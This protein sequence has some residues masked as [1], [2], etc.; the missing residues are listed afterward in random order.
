MEG[1]KNLEIE[2]LR[3][4]AILFVLYAHLGYL[5]SFSFDPTF[6]P[7]IRNYVQPGTGV[8]L[9]FC[10]SGFVITRS[11]VRQGLADSFAGFALP[12]WIRRFWR[13][14]PTI[15]LWSP[16]GAVALS[17]YAV[18]DIVWATMRDIAATAIYLQNLNAYYCMNYFVPTNCGGLILY[19][20]LSLEEQF[21]VLF[22]IALWFVPRRIILPLVL[23]ALILVQISIPRAFAMMSWLVRTDAICFGVLLGMLYGTVAHAIVQPR[24]LARSLLSWAVLIALAVI[25]ATVDAPNL[26]F[27]NASVGMVAFCSALLIWL[28]SYESG[29]AIPAGRIQT[30]L[31]YIGSRSFGLYVIHYPAAFIVRAIQNATTVTDETGIFGLLIIPDETGIFGLLIIVSIF[32]LAEVN[33]RLVEVPLRNYGRRAADRVTVKFEA[34]GSQDHPSQ[35]PV[36]VP[37]P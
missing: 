16:I 28:A 24:F 37:A 7:K 17:T 32:A 12:F 29:Y 8:D 4:I 19:W 26:H 27:V 25:I 10:I 3:G 30:I 36:T 11:I 15:L 23:I 35:S 14:T 34:P 6:S 31:A 2:A 21:Y 22:P 18:S 13:L 5:L 33:F 1:R 20:S 9:F